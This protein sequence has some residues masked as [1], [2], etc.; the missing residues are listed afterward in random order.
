MGVV[1]PE[2][3]SATTAPP[4]LRIN[5]VTILTKQM[6]YINNICTAQKPLIVHRSRCKSLSSLLS[7][8]RGWLLG[9]EIT[10]HCS[11]SHYACWCG[12]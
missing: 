6:L 1:P 11:A 4:V 12:K 5:A 3:G 7:N 9:A 10:V 8:E 2:D